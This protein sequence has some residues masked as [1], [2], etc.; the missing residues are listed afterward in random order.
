MKK[1]SFLMGAAALMMTA[2]S[3]DEVVDVAQTKGIGFSSFVNKSTRATADTDLSE[4]NLEKFG[5]WGITYNP[6]AENVAT[7]HVSSIFFG[8]EVKKNGT[9]WEYSPLRYWVAGNNYRFSAIAP[10]IETEGVLAVEQ[11]IDAITDFS[12]V[13]GG[14]KITF[15]NEKANAAT[16]LCYAFNKVP[17]A[18]ANQDPVQLD[19]SH[20]LSRVM[21]TFKNG[22]ASENSVIEVKDIKITNATSKATIDK[23]QGQ[24]LWAAEGTGTFVIS[25]PKV[26][27]QGTSPNYI[28]GGS[29]QQTQHQY[30]IPLTGESTYQLSFTVR[31]LNFD[32]SDGENGSF[33]E[34]ASYAHRVNLPATAFENNKSYN[35]VAEITPK[36]IDPENELYPIVFNPKVGNWEDFNNPGTDIPLKEDNN[37]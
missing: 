21:F 24:N 26:P 13:Q 14:L 16:D 2:C 10:Y 19:F 17:N 12:S 35:F 1:L 25:F 31:L 23:T 29:Q 36:S 8:Q 30:L 6:N 3:S 34:V 37:E 11:S 28:L 20:M 7:A 33:D 27:M 18:A 9:A 22:F 4:K 32:Q 5:V 15:D